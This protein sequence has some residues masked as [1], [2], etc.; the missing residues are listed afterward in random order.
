MQL[1]A[2]AAK[3]TARL[4]RSTVHGPHGH[5]HELLQ[6]LWRLKAWLDVAARCILLLQPQT[7]IK[8]S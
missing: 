7:G 8:Q 2:L 4:S 6:W 3:T 5:A 1:H